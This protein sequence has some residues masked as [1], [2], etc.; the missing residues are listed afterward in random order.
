MKRIVSGQTFCSFVEV[1]LLQAIHLLHKV[2]LPAQGL[3]GAGM[4][5]QIGPQHGLLIK[6]DNEV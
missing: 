5:L 6:T 4:D 1:I 3:L 2:R